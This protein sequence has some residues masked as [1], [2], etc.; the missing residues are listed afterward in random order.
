MDKEEMI[1]WLIDDDLNNWDSNETGR[2]EYF[3]FILRTGFVGYNNQTDEE[4]ANE[5]MERKGL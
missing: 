3:E 2:A 1:E 5:I 4:L